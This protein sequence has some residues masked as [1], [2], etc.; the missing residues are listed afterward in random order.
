MSKSYS[1]ESYATEADA[2]EPFRLDLSD[3]E[4][5]V[6]PHPDVE[7]TLLIEEAQFTRDRLRLICGD[8]FER[9]MDL[10]K[11]KDGETLNRLVDDMAA[12]FKVGGSGNSGALRR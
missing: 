2:R 11:S 12:H 7:T 8:Q 10:L 4:Q 5:I 9:I 3:G 6:I 1:F